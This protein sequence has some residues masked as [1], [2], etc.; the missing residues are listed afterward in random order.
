M[1][2]YI[3][4]L[5]DARELLLSEYEAAKDSNNQ[6]AAVVVMLA[7]T[8]LEVRIVDLICKDGK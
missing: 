7:L 6:H 1:K 2:T 8:R 5:T 3:D 4:G